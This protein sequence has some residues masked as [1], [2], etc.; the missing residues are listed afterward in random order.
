MFIAFDHTLRGTGIGRLAGS[1]PA[2]RR[3]ASLV[4]RTI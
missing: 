4:L 2:L 3:P 1:N